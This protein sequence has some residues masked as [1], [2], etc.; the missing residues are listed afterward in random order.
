MKRSER[1]ACLT[2]AA[3][4]AAVLAEAAA[5]TTEPFAASL[6]GWTNNLDATQWA[7]TNQA[8][9]VS[10]GP[11]I[12]PQNAALESGP[13]ASSGAFAGD[14]LAAGVEAIGFSF[15]AENVRPSVLKLELT[16]GTNIFFQDLRPRM[17]AAGTTNNFLV[18]LAARDAARWSGSPVSEFQNTLTNITRVAIRVTTS[19]AGAQAYRLDDLFLDLLPAA[20]ALAA[21]SGNTTAVTLANLRT[22]FAYRVQ[23]AA[24]S[25]AAWTNAAQLT[26]TSRT[27]TITLSNAPPLL[28]LR[29]EN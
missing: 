9:R 25:S 6:N 26:A 20:A 17:T 1:T 27:E 13:G 11:N 22:G 24:D 15:L 8:A 5:L 3:A 21:T 29:L 16:G 10:F 14:R 19:G 12:L 28:F 23:T 7:A 18:S 4:F 2:A